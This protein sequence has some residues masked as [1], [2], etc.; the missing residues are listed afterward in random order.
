MAS[1]GGSDG[2][3][4]CDGGTSEILKLKLKLKRHAAEELEVQ[5]KRAKMIPTPGMWFDI[6]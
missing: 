1:G 6:P 3:G 5:F 2:R 4:S